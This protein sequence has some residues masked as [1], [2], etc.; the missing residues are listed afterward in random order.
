MKSEPVV[1]HVSATGSLAEPH[2]GAGGLGTAAQTGTAPIQHGQGGA[3]RSK[4]T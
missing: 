4:R 2:V 3:G 1:N